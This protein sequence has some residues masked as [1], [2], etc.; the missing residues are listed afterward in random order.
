MFIYSRAIILLI[1]SLFISIIISLF[2]SSTAFSWPADFKEGV[3][4]NKPAAYFSGYTL[5]APNNA[6]YHLQYP[7]SAYNNSGFV[8]LINMQ[9]KVVHTWKTPGLAWDAKLLPNGNLLVMVLCQPYKS[10]FDLDLTWAGCL[11]EFEWMKI[12]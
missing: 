11:Y 7:N 2:I 6:M 12:S 4:I 3:T 1:I 5:F 9:G 8:Y 10:F